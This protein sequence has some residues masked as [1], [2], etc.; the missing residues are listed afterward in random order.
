MKTFRRMMN[1]LR[2][3]LFGRNREQEMA[4]EID[5]PYPDADRGEPAFGNAAAESPP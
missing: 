1:R 5:V 2:G 3:A 4:E